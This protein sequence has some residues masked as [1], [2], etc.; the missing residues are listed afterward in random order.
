MMTQSWTIVNVS[1]MESFTAPWQKRKYFNKMFDYGNSEGSALMMLMTDTSSLGQGDVMHTRIPPSLRVI[2]DPILGRW[3]NDSISFVGDYSKRWEGEGR[4]EI[5]DISSCVWPAFFAQMLCMGIEDYQ[6]DS[7][8]SEWENWRTHDLVRTDDEFAVMMTELLVQPEPGIENIALAHS[9]QVKR[10]CDLVIQV[11]QLSYSDGHIGPV[12]G[13]TED[14]VKVAEIF[15]H[16]VS[17]DG[18][19]CLESFVYDKD[20]PTDGFHIVDTKE[21]KIRSCTQRRVR[22]NKTVRLEVEE[23]Y[24]CTN[25]VRGDRWSHFFDSKTGSDELR[26]FLPPSV[27]N[28]SDKNDESLFKLKEL[29][30]IYDETLHL[31]HKRK[32][33]KLWM[34]HENSK[35]PKNH[36]PKWYWSAVYIREDDGYVKEETSE[37]ETESTSVES[38]LSKK[39]KCDE[40][41]ISHIF[42][43]PFVRIVRLTGDRILDHH[44]WM[45]DDVIKEVDPVQSNI[46]RPAWKLFFQQT[47]MDPEWMEQKGIN[48]YSR[49]IGKELMFFGPLALQR[50]R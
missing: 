26:C 29:K 49:N 32:H 9:E 38:L 34:C 33:V 1:R 25:F 10:I 19:W 11:L 13:L 8:K 21:V 18:V 48:K 50:L 20:V 44:D 2:I 28:D 12:G 30:S 17:K 31:F 36:R 3:C 46:I 43:Y 16:F 47:K 39:W 35:F 15:T 27:D 42:L 24:V 14:Y 7:S 41:D 37:E 22:H 5:K 6:S 23:A 4:K 40:K 45:K